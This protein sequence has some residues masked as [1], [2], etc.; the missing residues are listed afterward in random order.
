MVTEAEKLIY[1]LE[2]YFR[3]ARQLFLWKS[4]SSARIET[5]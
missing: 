4:L 1:G 3:P 2:N 5:L